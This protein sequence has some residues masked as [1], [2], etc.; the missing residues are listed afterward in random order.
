MPNALTSSPFHRGEREIQ[1][2]LGVREQTED[3]GHRFIRTYMPE[4]HRAFL[5]PA[6][7]PAHRI[8]RQGWMS[9]GINTGGAPRLRAFP[10]SRQIEDRCPS[11]IRRSPKAQF[12]SR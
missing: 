7:F 11:N 10:R 1:T 9:V 12:I 2:R 8:S 5:R 6:I 4:E 3:I